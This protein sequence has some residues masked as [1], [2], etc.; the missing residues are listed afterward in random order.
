MGYGRVILPLPTLLSQTLQS[1]KSTTSNL[2]RKHIQLMI[3]HLGSHNRLGF[4]CSGQ[5]LRPYNQPSQLNSFSAADL[6]MPA[7]LNPFG[8][9]NLRNPKILPQPELLSNLYLT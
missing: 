5:G 2:N 9:R 6:Q 4:C 1:S 3:V 7:D 8:L